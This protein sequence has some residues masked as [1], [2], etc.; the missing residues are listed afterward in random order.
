MKWFSR[1]LV[2]LLSLAVVAMAAA[3]WWLSRPLPLRA[4]RV[5]VSIEPGTNPREVARL[6]RE[7]G[8]QAHPEL[9]YQWFRWSGQA[10][11]IRAGS[12]EIEQ[13]A[14]ARSLLDK[15]VRGDEALE[16]LRLIDG[17]TF[18]QVRQAV[19][20]APNLKQ[21]IGGLS[22]AQVAAALGLPGGVVEGHLFPDTYAYSRGVSDVTVLK[23]AAAAMQR[24][25]DTAWA[26]R[27]PGLPLASP[28]AALVLASVVEKETGTP[29]DRGRIAAVFINRLRL[30]MP[31][32]SDPTVIF[33]MG[34]RF[35]GN[36]RRVDLATDTPWNT[37]TRTGL[38]PTPIALPGLAAL[39]AT[40]HPEPSKALYFVARGDGSSVFS[41]TL[42]DHNRAVNQF[43]KGQR[44]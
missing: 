17:W 6:W 21:T 37:Y 32:Q 10:R 26:G 2:V 27:A 13:G 42:D 11:R 22:D 20:A 12:Y 23:R 34:T 16:N 19:A 15:M 33:G 36:L 28:Q 29:G 5:E 31:L 3:W 43:Q 40:L 8:V 24:Q 18:R 38:P 35:D 44:P 14:T 25:L 9:L 7:A 4:E 41:E 1:L 39:H 30:G